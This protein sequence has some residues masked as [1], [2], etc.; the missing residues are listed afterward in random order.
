MGLSFALPHT[1]VIYS[2]KIFCTLSITIRVMYQA[3]NLHKG[4]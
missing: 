1:T 4:I 3:S 2:H